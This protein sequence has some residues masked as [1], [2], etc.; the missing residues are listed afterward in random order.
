MS[1]VIGKALK[2]S[3]WQSLGGLSVTA[4]NF[5]QTLVY[6]QVLGPAGFGSL[7]TSQAQVL[8]WVMLV[9]LGLTAGLISALTEAE[10]RRDSSPRALLKAAMAIRVLGALAGAA[11]V[12][13][14]ARQEFSAGRIGEIQLWQDLAYIPYLFAFACQQTAVS[15]AT[16]RGRQGLANAASFL[17]TAMAVSVSV[18]LVLRGTPLYTLLLAQSV[19]G[20]LIAL[21]IFVPI[22]GDESRQA[23]GGDKKL[24]AALRSLFLNSWPYAVVFAAVTV[25]A[26]ADQIVTTRLLG[27][28]EGGQYGLATRLVAIPVLVA[29]SVAF[30]T[31]PDMQRIGRDAP[32]KVSLYAGTVLKV[33]FRFGLPAAFLFLA[34]V[35]LVVTPLVPKYHAALWL[36]PWFAP[37]VWAYWMHSFAINAYWGLRR[38]REIVAVH[39]LALLAYAL[40]LVPLVQWQGNRGA[41]L[42]YCLFGFCLLAGAVIS[43][44]RCGALDP[45]FRLYGRFTQAERELWLSIREKIA[46]RFRR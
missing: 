28:E 1:A 44:R 45:G 10:T 15:Y 20:F 13:W 16:F 33:L 37:G 17:G 39:L 32:E 40:A 14:I 7:I 26:R 12:A 6:A 36:L 5:L 43:M 29:A 46:R 19:W 24:S 21:L 8:I 3:A 30:A 25:W 38:F 4:L 9:D 34:G 35:A 27:T 23:A 2:N 31:F 18:F 41:V 22:A 42:A 11:A